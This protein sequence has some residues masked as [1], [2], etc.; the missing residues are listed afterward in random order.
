MS[1]KLNISQEFETPTLQQWRQVVDRDLQGAPYDKKLIWK[2]LEGIAVE[3]LF[4]R[5]DL[6]GVSHLGTLPGFGPYVRGTEPLS[7]VLP[8]WQIRQDSLLAAPEDVNAAVRD[9]IA[10]GQTAIGIRLDNAARRG[11]DGDSPEAA[12]RAGRGGMT[13]SSINGIRIALQDID[14]ERHPVSY[15][16]GASALPVLAMHLALADE[17]GIDRR[18]LTGS[19][20]CD[21]IR[22]LVKTGH[23]RG[24]A[25]ALRYREMEEMVRFCAAECPG[26]RPVLV[27]GHPW[28]NGG[29]TAVQELAYTIASGTEYLREMIRRGV[30]PDRASLAMIFSFSVSSNLF[31]EI[32]KLRAAR[33]LW[34]K[35]V[36]AF[37]ATDDFAPRMFMHVRT[38][39]VTKTKND[40][41]NNMIRA[42]LEAFAGAV[43]GCDSMYVAPF[44]EVIGRPDEFSSRVA[45]NQQILLQEEV[46]LNKVVDAAGG[47]YY[48]ESLTDSVGRSAW[49]LFQKVES[50]GGIVEALKSG[51]VQEA[52][53]ETATMRAKLTAQR[54]APIVG[55]NNY[56][57][58]E[59]KSVEKAH[60]ARLE[61]LAERRQR[62]GLLKRMRKNSEIRY[63]LDNLTDA[64]AAETP[65]AVM[66]L[67]ISAAVKGATIGEMVGAL[68]AATDGDEIEIEPIPS[69]RASEPYESLRE[70]ADAYRKAKGELPKMMLLT[71]GPLGM[72][73]ARADFSYGFYTAGGFAIV[74]AN[75]D[76]PAAGVKT[77]LSENP[78]AVTLCSDDPTYPEFAPPFIEALRKEKPEMLVYIAGA[79]DSME[80]L[81]EAGASGFIHLKCNQLQELENLH[82][83]L[84]IKQG[85]GA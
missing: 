70:N 19:V 39:A 43:G 18:M 10:R 73:R 27:N 44:D 1:E 62:L 6:D 74:E 15:R 53:R 78:L 42:A 77:V 34:A 54:R 64:M 76:D 68:N 40:P 23:V 45:R 81:K 8:K 26:I 48:V 17:R 82:A 84:S 28:H 29:A 83:K 59:E 49:E 9:G 75:A 47:S 2:T 22:E 46:H 55:V 36:K 24:G 65:G 31:M 80:Q 7:G 16:T 5:Q 56:A 85:A 52:I 30:T 69:R 67:A 63:M 50:L 14:L 12:N 3:P 71:T 11:F 32:A 41:Y 38:S 25:L 58:P 60:I 21:P 51:V 35:V 79:P 33:M 37:G 61:F 66:E 57:N 20:E 72:R 13:V 4:T